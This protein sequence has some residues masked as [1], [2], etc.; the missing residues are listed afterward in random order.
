M[1][2]HVTKHTKDGEEYY[3]IQNISVKDI[4]KSIDELQEAGYPM[5]PAEVPKWVSGYMAEHKE[6]FGLSQKEADYFATMERLSQVLD[7]IAN[8]SSSDKVLGRTALGLLGLGVH[9]LW[10]WYERRKAVQGGIPEAHGLSEDQRARAEIMQM[11]GAEPDPRM[12][13]YT[14]TI[15]NYAMLMFLIA[16][17][18]AVPSNRRSFIHNMLL[19]YMENLDSESYDYQFAWQPFMLLAEIDNFVDE[20]EFDLKTSQ[21]GLGQGLEY[22]KKNIPWPVRVVVGAAATVAGKRAAEAFAEQS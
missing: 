20:P 10:H 9:N 22:S 21:S 16:A 12:V 2:M 14:A 18:K 11:Q 7:R 19:S 4:G 5:V 3:V 13:K 8:H 1:D 6:V 17:K 15:T